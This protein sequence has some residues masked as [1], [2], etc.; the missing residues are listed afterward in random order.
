MDQAALQEL[1]TDLPLGAVRYVDETAST[2]DDALQ[3]LAEGAPDASLVCAGMQTRGRGRMERVWYSAP[4]A[5][6]AFSVIFHAGGDETQAVPLLAPFS[7][8]AVCKAL[9]TSLGLSPRIKWPN[10]VLLGGMKVAGILSEAVWDG[11]LCQGVVIGI[12]VN[13]APGSVPPETALAFP[14]GSVEGTAGR[15]VDRW[16]LLQAV[17]AELLRSRS[18]IGNADFFREWDTRLAF[19]GE[20]VDLFPP[21]GGR[22]SGRLVGITPAGSLRIGLDDGTTRDVEAGDVS[23]RPAPG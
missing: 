5:S 3:W 19:K 21:S 9:E 4:G 15:K 10:D 12:G 8:L 11:P 22:V 6:L 23:L 17:I 7:G 14:A 1:L 13:V 18:S 2:N 16:N 20:Q